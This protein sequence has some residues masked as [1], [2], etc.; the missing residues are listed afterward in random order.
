MRFGSL[1]VPETRTSF[2]VTSVR[3]FHAALYHF[4]QLERQGGSL[5]YRYASVVCI[6]TSAFRFFIFLLF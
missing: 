1:A 4:M 2:V 3:H 5:T 6:H